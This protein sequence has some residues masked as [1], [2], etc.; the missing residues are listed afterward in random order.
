LGLLKA[1]LAKCRS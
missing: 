1:R